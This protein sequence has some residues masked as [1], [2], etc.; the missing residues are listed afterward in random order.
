MGVNMYPENVV[1]AVDILLNHRFDKKEPKNNNNI[2]RNENRN[3]NDTA[4][5]ITTQSSVNQE[6]AKNALCYR[7]GKKGHYANK[8]PEKKKKTQGSMG[9]EEGNDARPNWKRSPMRK[10]MTTMQ[11]KHRGSRTKAKPCQNG[12]VLS[13]EKR[14][15][16]T[17]ENSGQLEQKETAFCWT[18]D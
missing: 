16:I 13:L 9:S 1:K 14:V 5:T 18:T 2:Q 11:A 3:N 17:M 12:M 10:K 6:K 4:S 15:S 8:C 7:C